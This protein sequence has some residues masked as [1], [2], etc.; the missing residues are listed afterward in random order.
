MT[1]KAHGRMNELFRKYQDQGIVSK[2]SQLSYKNNGALNVPWNPNSQADKNA[3]ERG[4]DFGLGLFSDPIHSDSHDYP[5]VVK[6]EVPTDWL[7]PLT[8]G[9]KKRLQGSAD[10]YS[11]DYYSSGV[12]RHLPPQEAK[13]CYGNVTNPNWPNCASGPQTMS[14]G[15]PLTEQ[16]PDETCSSWLGDTPGAFRAHLQY[17]QKRWPAPK[18]I[19]VTEFGWAEKD[20][21]KLTNPWELVLD[22]GRQEY[23]DGHLNQIVQ[24]IQTDGV[25]IQGAWLWSATS[26]VEW[27]VGKEPRFGVQ[28]VNY[29]DPKL[30]RTYLGSSYFVKDFFQKHLG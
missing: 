1:I 23:Y 4:M 22:T 6:R 2:K 26:N 19:V 24:S 10:V 14:D 20:E 30:P 12:T 13:V 3:V 25:K 11:T 18:G 27:E 16:Y 15:W 5:A 8:E 17:L 7:P 9:D 21:A 28:S 29:T